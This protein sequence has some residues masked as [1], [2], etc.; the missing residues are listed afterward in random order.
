[1][2]TTFPKAQANN[3]ARH[4]L[5]LASIDHKIRR[6]FAQVRYCLDPYCLQLYFFDQIF[7]GYQKLNDEGR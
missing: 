7:D 3:C 1:M 6:Y 2:Q 5:E 4:S